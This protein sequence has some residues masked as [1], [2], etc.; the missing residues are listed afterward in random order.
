M[1][2]FV[3]DIYWANLFILILQMIGWLSNPFVTALYFME[4][5]EI[6]FFGGTARASDSRIVASF[7]LSVVVVAIFT[8]SDISTDA[9]LTIVYALAA[10]VL[11]KNWMHTM[12]LKKPFKVDNDETDRQ[13]LQAGIVFANLE[14][15]PEIEE[16]RKKE[17]QMCS[18]KTMIFNAAGIALVL[19]SAIVF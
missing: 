3:P 16:I 8:H 19:L 18:P 4:Q 15:N 1:W 6:L 11:S 14:P 5:G 7:L 17:R 10:I 9:D 13:K 2:L 12:G